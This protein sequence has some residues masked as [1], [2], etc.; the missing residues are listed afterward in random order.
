MFRE[1]KNFEP[2]VCP[3][4]E[5]KENW[6]KFCKKSPCCAYHSQGYYEGY[7]LDVARSLAF[8][9]NFNIIHGCTGK[10]EHD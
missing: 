9:D 8:G 3:D 1:L 5:P 4:F 6:G 2:E 7:G 10:S